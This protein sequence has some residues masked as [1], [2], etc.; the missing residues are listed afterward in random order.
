MRLQDEGVPLTTNRALVEEIDSRQES[1]TM[2][3]VNT[4]NSQ[5]NPSHYWN[6]YDA[7]VVVGIDRVLEGN[8]IVRTVR[9]NKNE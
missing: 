7:A 8:A 4:V 2:P 6:E 5:N 1:F 3:F 9:R